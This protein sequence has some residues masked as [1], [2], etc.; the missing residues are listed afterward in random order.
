MPYKTNEYLKKVINSI[1]VFQDDELMSDRE[2]S[3]E[4]GLSPTMV[5]KIKKW[6]TIPKLSTLRKLKILGIKIPKPERE[7]SEIPQDI[8]PKKQYISI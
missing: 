3:L 2:L 7:A 4:A 8:A 6:T 5:S 1:Q